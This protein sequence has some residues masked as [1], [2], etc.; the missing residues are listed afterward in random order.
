MKQLLWLL[1][2]ACCAASVA[3]AGPN[4]GGRLVVHDTGMAYSNDTAIPPVTTPPADLSGVDANAYFG[5]VDHQIIWKVYAVFPPA[6]SP[7]L[8]ALT[9]GIGITS[10][11]TGGIHV[12]DAGLPNPGNDFE[13]SQ[14]G[15][16]NTNGASIGVTFPSPGGPKLTTVSEVYWFAGYAYGGVA[17]TP[18][19]FSTQP[20][21]IHP[22]V[23]IDDSVPQ[24]EDA[25]VGWGALGF[26][27]DPAAVEDPAGANA[28]GV[29]LQYANP[30]RAHS[31]IS[32]AVPTGQ[33][34]S[35]ALYDVQ[36]R[37]IYR[38]F[39]GTPPQGRITLSWDGRTDS[40]TSV[41]SGMYYLDVR[42][43]TVHARRA[44]VLMR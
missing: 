22:P 5:D 19:S 24:L 4:A 12:T 43:E 25:I 35:A 41:G 6:S 36:G 7:R 1:V 32:L 31:S 40:G 8:V 37:L 16:P 28:G 23:F 18:Q 29:R 10:A 13:V 14:D 20:H 11:G 27:S 30:Y 21:S 44:L 26:A 3:A 33:A 9:W 2:L 17:Y 38:L 34:I 42:G 39:D 15:W